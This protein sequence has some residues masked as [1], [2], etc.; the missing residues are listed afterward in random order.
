MTSRE[1]TTVE[2]SKLHQPDREEA[3]PEAFVDNLEDDPLLPELENKEHEGGGQDHGS[4]GGLL[5]YGGFPA[6]LFSLCSV[7]L[8]VGVFVLP[9]A[10]NNLGYISGTLCFL[11]VAVWSYA[12]N[13]ALYKAG[14]KV[15]ND[16]GHNVSYQEISRRAFGAPGEF[17]LSFF[18]AFT[19]LVGNSAHIK[20]VVGLL[21]DI[22]E[23][24]ITGSYGKTALSTGRQAILLFGALLVAFPL[25]GSKTLGALRYVS[26]LCVSTVLITCIWCV[27]ECMFWYWP[28]GQFQASTAPLVATS[29]QS[30]A[31]YIPAIAFAF[32][33]TLVLLPVL[34]E[35]K[36]KDSKSVNQLVGASTLMC[37]IGYSVFSLVMVLTFGDQVDYDKWRGTKASTV[38]YVFPAEHYGVTFLCFC[39]CIVITLLYPILNFPV[40]HSLET[41]IRILGSDPE[42]W[43]V[44]FRVR[45]LF[46]S[47]LGMV[48]V[49]Y[50]N[51]NA[52]SILQLFG[53]C[54]SWG[55]G[56]VCY[57]L[58]LAFYLKICTEETIARKSAAVVGILG[59]LVTVVAFT[60]ASFFDT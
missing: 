32:T 4:T 8:G 47:A 23:W 45:R 29:W 53:L 40:M 57:I 51:L 60:Y 7:S 14:V 26:T 5:K 37:L 21:H 27:G 28:H 11:L 31:I 34:S 25:C 12:S 44:S 20:T 15:K 13:L 41:M 35:Y 17:S 36:K 50:L 54:G 6:S 49:C 56:M 43:P 48:F 18:M 55:V 19:L 38:L 46:L 59:M 2:E 22:L 16:A 52:D 39:L 10:L 3:D 24:Y 30:Y 42:K 1:V 58:P 33:G 9:F